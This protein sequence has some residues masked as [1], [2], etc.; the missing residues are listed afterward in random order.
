LDYKWVQ[1]DLRIYGVLGGLERKGDYC[2]AH[3]SGGLYTAGIYIPIVLKDDKFIFLKS[4]FELE[5]VP[6]NFIDDNSHS[7]GNAYVNK[8]DA[9]LRAGIAF[10]IADGFA[11]AI[12]P[13][14]YYRQEKNVGFE[15]HIPVREFGGK[16]GLFA[17]FIGN[18]LKIE[19]GVGVDHDRFVFRTE[20]EALRGPYLYFSAGLH[21]NISKKK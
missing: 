17:S 21:G 6:I 9:S 18:L 11:M 1:L 4:Q 8:L 2:S 7:V 3:K 19:M 5:D 10:N 20:N 13:E 15:D 14:F 12:G 16:A